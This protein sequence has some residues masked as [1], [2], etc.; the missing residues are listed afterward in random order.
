[1]FGYIGNTTNSSQRYILTPLMRYAESYTPTDAPD[2]NVPAP[3]E[4]GIVEVRETVEQT[5]PPAPRD[6]EDD[7]DDGEDEPDE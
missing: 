4:E 3:E 7:P 5:M 1:M 2:A 6:P